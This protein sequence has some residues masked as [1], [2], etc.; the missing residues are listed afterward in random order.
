MKTVAEVSKLTGVSVR[1]LHHYD[2]IDLLKP[3]RITEAGYRLYDGE[4][5]S[6]LQT[7]LLFREL[8]FPLKQIKIILD[9]PNFDPMRALDDQ[10]QLLQLQRQRL[11]ALILHAQNLQKKGVSCM[12]FESFDNTQLEARA[13]EAR[14]KWGATPAYLEF[15]E[16]TKGQTPAQ[17]REDGDALMEIFRQFGTLRH[18]APENDTVQAKVSQLQSFITDH[19]YTCTPQILRGLGQMY[20]A[21]DSMT[22]NIDRA[23]GCGTAEFVHKA[24]EIYCK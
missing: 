23:G 4:A 1:T 9:S 5:L 6:R 22:E 7:I 3:T 21:G 14:E 20:I 17:Q 15:T 19:Y 11:D 24:I 13:A 12:N 10:I 2:A 8:K 18:L 16:K